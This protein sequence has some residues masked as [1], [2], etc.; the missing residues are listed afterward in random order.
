MRVNSE[1]GQKLT[2]SN[3]AAVPRPVEHMD[4]NR[5]TRA[6]LVSAMDEEIA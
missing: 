5:A 6:K 1:R 2:P 3:P 4:S